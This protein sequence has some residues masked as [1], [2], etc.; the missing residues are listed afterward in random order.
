MIRIILKI[1]ISVLFFFTTV[2]KAQGFQGKAL[3]QTKITVSDAVKKR[4]D[5]MKMP[6]DRK[7]FM[8]KMMKKRMEKIYVLDFN[9]TQSTYK[10]EKVLETPGENS[11]FSRSSD[12]VF[13]RDTK[14]KTFTNKKETFGKVFLIKDSLKQ[15]DWKLGKESK[16][17]GK[18]L[19]FKATAEKVV[20]NDMKRFSRFMKKEQSKDKA[21]DSTTVET[22]KTTTVT[23]WY[24]PE[25]PV[26]HGPKDYQGLP[27]LILEV[28]EGNLQM[29]CTE[30]V[31]NP[32]DKAKIEKPTKG[33]EITQEEYEAILEEKITE[34][35]AR[36]KSGRKK[37]SGGRGRHF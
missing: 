9:K 19:C 12:N 4:M 18:H 27:G 2:A 1:M 16:M 7:D 36:F 25:I 22:I 34:M 15:L 33:K 13:F 5:S 23:A 3:Y 17:I 20:K 8:M 21:K 10:E 11:R 14:A 29:Y 28:N 31:I 6:D 30:L 26:A 35:R 32:K 24:T 37:G